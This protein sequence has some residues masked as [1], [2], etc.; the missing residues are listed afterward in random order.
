MIVKVKKIDRSVNWGA[1]DPKSGK[2][3]PMFDNCEDKICPGLDKV[4]GILRTGL[5]EEEEREFEAKIGLET[6]AL[7]KSG[8]YWGLYSITIPE[9]GLTLNIENPSDA[10]AYKVLQADPN[11]A[12][13]LQALRTH[14][15]A[16]YV[17]TNEGA[18]AKVSNNK[19]NVIAKAYASFAKL[20]QAE[21]ID[22]LYM[23]GKDA[24][25]MDFEV[26]Q[27]RLGE[28]LDENPAKFLDVIGD[29][30]FKDKVWFMKLIKKGIVKKH[31]TG[32]GTN[33]PL[34]Y[35]D[36]MLGN[37]LEE[38]ITFV[39]DKEN[40]VIFRGLKAAEKEG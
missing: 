12:E 38:A 8:S 22:A 15:T 7:S 37:G 31:G 36:I 35:E 21:T 13:S 18:E 19:R 26:A 25:N 28:I 5:T 27:N 20:T 24:L 17:M 16:E 39:K 30:L 4:T 11:V 14:A 34:Y 6:G 40:Q 10:L 2:V 29:K 23:F 33:M 1:K 32:T 9:D 3:K